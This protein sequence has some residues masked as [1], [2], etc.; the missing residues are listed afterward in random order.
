MKLG[1]VVGIDDARRL[2]NFLFNSTVKISINYDICVSASAVNVGIAKGACSRYAQFCQ[3]TKIC[4]LFVLYIIFIDVDVCTGYIWGKETTFVG[5][6][7]SYAHTHDQR[8]QFVWFN[9]QFEANLKP[10]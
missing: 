10:I 7:V 2:S 9:C 1:G 8:T 5:L 3:Y 6:S 4:T